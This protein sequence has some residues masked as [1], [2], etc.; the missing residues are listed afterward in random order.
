MYPMKERRRDVLC[1]FS[2]SSLILSIEFVSPEC[3]LRLKEA[4]LS[5]FLLDDFSGLSLTSS[6]DA[7][8]LIKGRP[9]DSLIARGLLTAS[10]NSDTEL[11]AFSF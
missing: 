5:D 2:G 9:P 4:T 6:P 10:N 8:F 11:F 7:D 3:D 1:F